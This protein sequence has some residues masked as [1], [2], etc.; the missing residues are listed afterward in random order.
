MEDNG[1]ATSGLLRMVGVMA[2][3]VGIAWV[4]QIFGFS[5]GPTAFSRLIWVVAAASISGAGAGLVVAA[6]SLPQPEELRV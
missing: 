3:C 1:M 4:V 5:H 6:G 2:I